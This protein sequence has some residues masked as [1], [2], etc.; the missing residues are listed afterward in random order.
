MDYGERAS[1]FGEMTTFNFLKKKLIE[2][3]DKK[4]LLALIMG[5]IE[6]MLNT[7]VRQIGFSNFERRIHGMNAN[8]TAWE[9]PKKLSVEELNAIWRETLV[10]FYG[11]SGEVFTYEDTDYLWSYV[12]HFHRPFYVYAYAFGE[13][14][15]QSLYALQFKFGD[16]FEPMYLD[17]L[18]SGSTKNVVQLLKPFEL[19]PTDEN[20]WISGIKNSLGAMVEEAELLSR[21]LG[22]SV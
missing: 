16:K 12:S 11:A 2:K 4:F 8:F 19:D 3:G 14:L 20:F 17:L 13:L 10:P 21:E 22:V 1:I 6:D 5:K 15:T 18:R 7:A 9:P